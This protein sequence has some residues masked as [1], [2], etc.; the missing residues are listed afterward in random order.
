MNSNEI[1][2]MLHPNAHPL[3]KNYPGDAGYDLASLARCSIPD[4]VGDKFMIPTGVQVR[5][6]PGFYGWI[7]PRSSTLS[8]YGL[9]IVPAVIDSGYTGEL[10]VQA[11]VATLSRQYGT[12]Q[13]GDRIAQFIPHRIYDFAMVLVDELPAGERGHKGFGSTGR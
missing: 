8:R 6:P 3:V 9:E 13:E 5:M 4:R 11:I 1:L 7:M 2:M 12:I 10:F